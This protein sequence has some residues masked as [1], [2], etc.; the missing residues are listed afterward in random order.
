[1]RRIFYLMSG[2]AH[3]PYL[4]A[5][6]YTLRKWWDGPITV[7]AW[8][9]SIDL[10]L[11]IA[12]DKRL[13]VEARASTPSYRGKNDQFLAKIQIAINQPNE[14]T[15]LYLDADTTLHGK[16]DQLFHYAEQTGFCATQWND[17]QTNGSMISGRLETLRQFLDDVAGPAITRLQTEC[18]PSVNGGVWCAK[19]DSPVLPLWYAWAM[20]ATV[21]E[22]TF[23]A[24]EKVLHLMMERFTET[25]QFFTL[26]HFGQYNSSPK[27]QSIMLLTSQVV[28]RHYHGDSNV[29]PDKS[30]KGYELWW[31]I[32]QHCIEENIG[33]AAEWKD[34]T[35]NKWLKKLSEQH[36][37]ETV[38]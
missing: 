22:H 5:S 17:W 29:R 24:D 2:A 33:G 15:C 35:G 9:E 19:P 37:A 6:L 10:V 34:R 16:F 27:H 32:W 21:P 3:I 13:G 31:P 14:D 1:M 36:A 25:G 4:T 28:I 11:R 38:D 8:K 7:Y 20:R 30:I 12:E 26:E 23:I 18:W